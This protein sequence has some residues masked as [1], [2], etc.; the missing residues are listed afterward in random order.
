MAS[1]G[2]S[3]RVLDMASVKPLD[4]EAIEAAAEETGR[5]V[6]AEEH[7]LKG[8]LGSAVAMVA[9]RRHPF[10]SPSWAST[11]PTPSLLPARNC[12]T[13]LAYP[14]MAFAPRLSRFSRI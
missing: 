7:L 10:R 5:F 4:E 6:V 8:G 1:E 14:A 3:A 12:W 2:V 11:I 9:A 13:G